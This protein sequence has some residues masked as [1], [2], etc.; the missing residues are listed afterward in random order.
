LLPPAPG[1]HHW[2]VVLPPSTLAHFD[3]DHPEAR[4]HRDLVEALWQRGL[5]C[6]RTDLFRP[7]QRVVTG[8]PATFGR[9]IRRAIDVLERLHRIDPRA[10]ATLLASGDAV[11]I[12]FAV[13][14][15]ADGKPWPALRGLLLTPPATEDADAAADPDQDAARRHAA[16]LARAVALDE[17]LDARLDEPR[18]E[19]VT[20]WLR[21]RLGR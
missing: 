6:V 4:L 3:A 13:R 1:R 20:R 14:N 5:G 17:R 16:D 9:Q 15:L 18:R 10:E 21:G 2:C 11:E 8:H 19:G 7:G 12:A